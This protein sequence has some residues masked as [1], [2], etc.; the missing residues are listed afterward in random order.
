M[1][2]RNRKAEY[3]ISTE[4]DNTALTG[5]IAKVTSEFAGLEESGKEAFDGITTATG[6]FL[7][8]LGAGEG[9]VKKFGEIG[10]SAFGGIDKALGG[11]PSGFAGMIKGIKGSNMG[12]KAMKGA[13]A[14]TGI[15]LLVIAL[16]ELVTYLMQ[17]KTFI[18]TMNAALNRVKATIQPT[19][20]L[21]LNLGSA[22]AALFGGNPGLA[23]DIAANSVKKYGSDMKNA[24]A[25]VTAMN[26]AQR[27]LDKLLKEQDLLMAKTNIKAY[28]AR[29]IARDRNKTDK[30]R[31]EALGDLRDA[32]NESLNV[33]I[34][35]QKLEMET[36]E[37][38]SRIGK[39]SIEQQER[40]NE[41]KVENLRLLLEQKTIEF[42]FDE[43]MKDI[44]ENRLD[45]EQ[46]AKE[47]RQD[48]IDDQK[49]KD[50][51]ILEARRELL[52]DLEYLRKSDKDKALFDAREEYK[53]RVAIAGDDE[54]LQ[55]AA[56]TQWL[57]DEQAIIDDFQA[58]ADE[59]QDRLD[60]EKAQRFIDLENAVRTQEELERERVRL[61]YIELLKL[62]VEFGTGKEELL[63][64]Q[65]LA[66]EAIEEKYAK[67]SVVLAGSTN[68]A[69]YDISVKA[70]SALIDLSR[71]FQD[72]NEEN[73]EKQFN[74]DKALGIG[75]ATINT[76][77]AI[78][79]ALAKDSVAPFTRYASAIA[80]GA[81][82]LAQV[83]AI[84]K[85][86]F[87]GGGTVDN[88]ITTPPESVNEAPQLDLSFM[89][90]GAG[91]MGIQAY[92]V[93]NQMTNSQQAQQQIQDQAS[94][95]G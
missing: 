6:N 5:G 43:S 78:S 49:E 89:G 72:D 76:A 47:D 95:V 21:L 41:L 48:A 15:G 59:K 22:L 46:D 62:A 81:A 50:A 82:G 35:A 80:A 66:Y 8:K 7:S 10:G 83:V 51:D 63:E 1:A 11:L 92:V 71:A 88:N 55:A 61:H 67:K 2:R 84:K 14:S 16:G 37:R 77:I 30:E 29:N 40:V 64:K 75:T 70:I 73:A 25:N 26:K 36:L 20:D 65:A 68:E 32:Q 12:L 31:I 94:L 69:K 27:E 19:I 85:T 87:Q 24:Q 4:V 45:R 42:E 60:D 93:S 3:V 13:I 58:Q 39:L 38:Q 53:E 56:L 91:Q 17:S 28:E 18:D 54:G 52:A 33:E 34:R 44:E 90:A 86:T 23:F 57:T 74:T 79:D 9:T